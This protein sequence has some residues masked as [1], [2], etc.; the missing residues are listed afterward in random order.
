MRLAKEINGAAD[1]TL[2]D[3]IAIIGMAC[4]FPAAPDLDTYWQNILSKVDAVIDPPQDS[5]WAQ[6]FYDPESDANDRVYCRKGGYLGSLTEFDPFAH[7]VLPVAAEGG[8]PD[9]WL[10]LRVAYEAFKDAGYAADIP[11]RHRTAVILGKGNYPNRGNF[12]VLQHGLVAHQTVDIIRA[13]H[14]EY[15]TADLERLRE[16]L[17]RQL[18]RF[19]PDTVSGLIPNVTAGRIANR[20]DLMGPSY[21]IDA[22]CASSL[23][24]VDLA[25]RD[26]RARRCDLA[27]VGGIHVTAPAALGPVF[28]QLGA[29]SRRQQIRPFDS[30]ADGT[31]LGEGVGMVVLKRLDDARRDGHR[32]YALVKGIGT[33]SDGRG[34]S[35]TAPRTEG[36]I[37]A[38]ERAYEQTGTLPRTVGLIEAH[39]TGTPVGDANEIR[40]L[41]HVF[42]SRVGPVP[43]VALGSVKSMLG[44]LM[45]AAGMAGLIKMALALYHKVL[46]PTLHVEEP[47]PALELDKSPFYLNTE[48]RPW[49]Q[50]EPEM[51]RRAGVNAFGFGGINAHAILE[52][53]PAASE[54]VAQSRRLSWDAEVFI[55][56]AGSRPEL[57]E[58][59]R[60]LHQKIEAAHSAVLKDLAY[61]MNV[62]LDSAPYRVA[63]V[64]SSHADLIGKL[65]TTSKQLA[66]P[67]HRKIHDPKGVYFTEEPLARAGQLAFLFPGEGSQYVNMCADLCMEFPE[68]R[69]I[70]DRA[71]RVWAEQGRDYLPSDFLFPRPSLSETEQ[72]DLSERLWQMD[73]ATALVLSADDAFHSLLRRLDIK[74]DVVVGHSTGEFAALRASGMIDLGSKGETDQFARDLYHTYE[75]VFGSDSLSLAALVAVGAESEVVCATIGPLDGSV[76]VAM[77]NCQQQS[78]IVGEEWAIEPAVVR[79]RG[80][81]LL[82]ERL[83]FDRPY[84]TPL[85]GPYAEPLR[86]FFARW[87]VSAPHVRT[88]SCTTASPFPV[89]VERIRELA[90]EQWM[91]R[92]EFRKTVQAMYEDGVRIF[93][94]VGPRGNLSAFVD[95]I[96][97]GRPHL[98]A[99]V[100]LP[101]RSGI[102]QLNHLVAM[103]AA[104]GVSMNLNYLYAHR[105]PHKIGWDIETASQF[106]DRAH[107]NR[108]TLPTDW[109][110]MALSDEAIRRLLPK[111]HP[112]VA[113]GAEKPATTPLTSRDAVSMLNA[114]GLTDHAGQVGIV[115]A[116]S[117]KITDDGERALSLLGSLEGS[118]H[119]ISLP[120]GQESAPSSAAQVMAA[121][122]NTVQQMLTAQH[123]VMQ[124]FLVGRIGA[125][126]RSP[127]PSTAVDVREAGQST[128]SSFSNL[129]GEMRPAALLDEQRSPKTKSAPSPAP[130]ASSTTD[131]ETRKQPGA[132][133]VGDLLLR[134]VSERTGY[135]IDMLHP[136]LDLE[137]DLG[138]DSIKRVEILG[139][140][141]QQANAPQGVDMEALAGLRTLRE[142]I[143]VLAGCQ[144][145]VSESLPASPTAAAKNSALAPTV[146]ADPIMPLLGNV[147]ALTPG[148]KLETLREISIEEDLIL[149]HHTFGRQVS[150]ADP[151]LTGLPVV[152]FTV[153]MEIMAEAGAV[154][155]PGQRLVGM[156]E[157][158]G[159]RWLTLDEG[160][161]CLRVIAERKPGTT[162]VEVR[163]FDGD[164]KEG[165]QNKAA[166][167]IFTGKLLFAHLYPEPTSP[168]PFSLA[169]ERPAKCLPDRLYEE[170]TFHGPA[171]RGVVSLDGVG[172]DGARATLKVLPRTGLLRSS[173]DPIFVLDP[174]LLD[175][176][177]QV[178][179]LWA[180]DR[181]EPDHTYFP[182]HLEELHLFGPPLPAGELLNCRAQILRV[183]DGVVRANVDVEHKD[184][185]ACIRFRGWEDRS[186]DVPWSVMRLTLAPRD[187]AISEQCPRVAG[188]FVESEGFRAYRLSLEAFPKGFF[189]NHGA[190]WQRAIAHTV[191]SRSEREVW[192][193]LRFPPPRRIE[194]LLG[195]IA[196]KDALRDCLQKNYGLSLCPADVEIQADEHGRPVVQ[197]PWSA[198][199]PH[200]PL[201][202][203]AHCGGTAVAVAGPG[204]PGTG[205]GVDIERIDRMSAEAK[206]LAFSK[207]EQELLNS[208][209]QGET[210]EWPLRVWCAKEAVAKALGYGMPN[211]SQSLIAQNVD[212]VSGTVQIRLVGELARRGKSGEGRPSVLSAFTCREGDWIMATCLYGLNLEMKHESQA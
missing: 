118:A 164:P 184:G 200:M 91:S 71:D 68:V 204:R 183:A 129:D 114:P 11:K 194:W 210:D 175:Q 125:P 163:I 22:A 94:E 161:L 203:I 191:L 136:N 52:E 134:L 169:N 176:L 60:R 40:A 7:G 98:A 81:G 166:M 63:I 62:A 182:F 135:P 209:S 160:R 187:T 115:G 141:Q 158:R 21:T 157:V 126:A 195:R 167:P 64:A 116:E 39:G 89:D 144:A 192:H 140:F 4:L 201:V 37:L 178:V 202:S 186:F 97:R 197:G 199:G 185:R 87:L 151:E 79:L 46:P 27:L 177:G 206:R 159:S 34:M 172:D 49:M 211:G 19:Q 33:A 102:T 208:L 123:D 207:Q 38:L 18:P 82:C 6:R 130:L 20:L 85:F 122:L 88:Y 17:K 93:V 147:I 54:V 66:D 28:C 193:N 138:I 142:I 59:V 50:P 108:I 12:S 101:H 2:G 55:L 48:S 16:E 119:P 113:S 100:N 8:E 173:P 196:A 110:V 30:K 25:V 1:R 84:H 133:G 154:L 70:F 127:A 103:L 56:S 106:S 5:W 107:S 80:R 165:N 75:E 73:G 174:V 58:R 47:N 109:P 31:I 139:S 45:P 171:M 13:L 36:A 86:E 26:L 170:M 41:R 111:P 15:S 146:H 96:L 43:R 99:P 65:D 69:Q 112:I 120:C 180:M 153:A 32:I 188:S 24:A 3:G 121:H 105:S 51:P 10:A 78:V 190:I 149:R 90:I 198:G 77:D 156:R 92:V 145:A 124:A 132:E 42:G 152:P 44:H 155:M 67:K 29:L 143:D 205:V 181:L 83:P 76:F 72:K 189:T 53:Y 61:S 179:G 162:D 35:V 150:I 148:E 131:T 23:V 212:P 128:M 57:I 137:A 168:E 14:P 95:A 9:Q 74:P 104:H 117:S